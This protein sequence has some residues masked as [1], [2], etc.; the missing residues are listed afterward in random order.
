MDWVAACSNG[1]TSSKSPT[2]P[3]DGTIATSLLSIEADKTFP[4]LRLVRDENGP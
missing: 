1:D 3:C 2:F 4:Y